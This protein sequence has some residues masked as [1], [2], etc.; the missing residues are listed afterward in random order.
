MRNSLKRLKTL[1]NDEK[2]FETPYNVLSQLVTLC[3]GMLNTIW[4]SV[5]KRDK[6]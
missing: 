1:K 4:G 6:V 5:T 2:R 3:H